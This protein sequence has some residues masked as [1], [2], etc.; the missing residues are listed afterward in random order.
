MNKTVLIVVGAVSAFI[1]AILLTLFGSYVSAVNYGAAAEAGIKAAYTNNQNVLAQYS[2]KVQE[3]AQVPAMYTEDF[4]KVTRA[5]IEGRY[6]ANG[7]SNVGIDDHTA[8]RNG[9]IAAPSQLGTS[10]EPEPSQP[11]DKDTKC[12]KRHVVAGYGLCLS[13][14]VFANPWSYQNGGHQSCGPTY[15]VYHR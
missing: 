9:V 1:V 14:H 13:I 12:P 5:A 2:Q 4:T 15:G 3:V 8:G 11:K 10:V 6:G 7:S